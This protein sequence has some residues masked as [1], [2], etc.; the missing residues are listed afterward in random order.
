MKRK[1][2]K[3]L[4]CYF[5]LVAIFFTL[6][7]FSYLLPNN[8][9]RKHVSE[10]VPILKS[11]GLSYSP[12]F[13]EIGGTL[14]THTDAL[15]LNIAM[16]KGIN[17]NAIKNA[18]ENSFYED[19]TQGGI[20][21]LESALS[22]D[23]NNHEYSRYWHGIQ[24][25]LRPL[26]IFLNYTEIRYLLMIV[27]C[28]LSAIVFSMLGKQL[29]TKYAIAFAISISMMFVALI[30]ASLQYSSIFIVMLLSIISVLKLY[31]HNKQK[32][33]GLLFFIIGAVTT[34]F[35]LLT[36][37]L[38]TFGFPMILV[39]L[40]EKDNN[41]KILNQ[42]ILVI[43][44]GIIW[45]LGYGL[46]FFT[47]WVLASIILHRDAI[48]LALDQILFRVNGDE[49]YPV[50]RIDTIRSNFTYF[51]VPVA[52]KVLTF[53]TIIWGILLIKYRK[54][55]KKNCKCIIP[56]LFVAIIPYVWYFVFAGH[57]GIHAWFTYK[58]QAITVFALLS[59]YALTIE[60]EENI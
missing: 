6:I 16:N 21:S 50:N 37:P 27:I 44:L 58:I 38:V 40:L 15:M 51:F 49:K 28:C 12:L 25:F 57:S 34:Y 45:C 39:I 60:T 52:K 55:I 56:I 11:E 7:V 32:Q 20:S 46:L 4:L 23:V 59:I 53:I 2:L 14:D 17:K 54:N 26:L 35:D 33:I 41:Q 18:V 19:E 29:G 3:Y 13:D 47:K 5:I 1:I 48:K 10:S 9:I 8:R 42:I 31:K 30:P 24:V 22:K 43:K 36:Y